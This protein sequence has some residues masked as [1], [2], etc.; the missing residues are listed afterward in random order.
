M[1]I[2]KLNISSLILAATFILLGFSSCKLSING[3]LDG[4]WQVMTVEPEV[5]EQ[6][7]KNRL[8]F[9]FYQHICQLT[10]YNE[11]VLFTGN[12]KYDEGKTLYIDFPKASSPL[13]A[14]QLKQYGINSNPVNFVVEHISR[15]KLI[16]RDGETI[17]T[18]RKF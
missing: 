17:V 7:I 5:T 16:L 3:D 10:A 2:S 1:K 15:N 13:C 14:E 12:M 4:Q 8:Y 6:P 11:S 9:C 18:L